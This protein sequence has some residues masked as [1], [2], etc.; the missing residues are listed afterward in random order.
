VLEGADGTVFEECYQ[1]SNGCIC[2]SVK[3][4]AASFE[5]SGCA[6]TLSIGACPVAD[7]VNTLETIMKARDKFDYVLV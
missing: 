1:L 2:C 6:L 4:G 5:L 7:L 3:H